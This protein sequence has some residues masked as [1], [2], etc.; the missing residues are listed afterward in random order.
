MIFLVCASSCYNDEVLPVEVDPITEP[1][2]YELNIQPFFDAN[3]VTCHKG[4]IPPNLSASES[5]NA[6]ITGSYIN[7]ATPENSLLYTKIAIGGSME[8]YATPEERAMVLAWI[9]QGAQDN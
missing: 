8:P 2:S 1:Q 6:L 4:S 5:Y 3:C 7:T 9:E